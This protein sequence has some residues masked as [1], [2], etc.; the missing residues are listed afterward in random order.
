MMRLFSNTSKSLSREKS[1]NWKIIFLTSLHSLCHSRERT[2]P[3]FDP[4]ITAQ[5]I[6]DTPYPEMQ[7]IIGPNL[8]PKSGRMLLTAENGTGKSAIGL[9]T[10]VCTILGL[11]WFGFINSHK[12]ENLGKPTFPVAKGNKVLYIDYEVPHA[13]RKTLRLQPLVQQYGNAFLPNLAFARM[14]THFRL[15]AGPAFDQLMETI[16]TF[17]PDLLIVDPL[18]SSHSEEENSSRMRVPLNHV[19]RL[20]DVSGAAAIVIHHA[21]TKKSRDHQGQVIQ[22]G[23]KEQS[24]GHSS[25]TD[26][27]DFN[28]LVIDKTHGNGHVKTL[29]LNFAKT[30]YSHQRQKKY[31]TADIANMIF[32][33]AKL[34]SN[35]KI[36]TDL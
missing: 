23:A 7:F 5:E 19:D 31:I 17:K 11:P 6:L 33:P 10:S 20:I 32:A 9:Y 4:L 22:K 15:D 8:L 18:S 35:E 16:G 12:D 24:R 13:I 25:I 28:L 36:L 26:W 3:L 34:N 1:E 30:R 21:S 14:P 29:E 2:N 27:A